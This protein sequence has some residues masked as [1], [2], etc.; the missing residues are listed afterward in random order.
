MTVD[1]IREQIG[2]FLGFSISDTPVPFVTH[3]D[4][5]SQDAEGVVTTAQETCIA[6]G[7]VEHIEHKRYEGKHSLTQERF[8]HIVNWLVWCAG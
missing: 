6:M 8:D 2:E 3:G 4:P 5:F 7:I 1:R